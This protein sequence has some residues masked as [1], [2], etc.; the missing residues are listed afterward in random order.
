MALQT[1][2]AHSVTTD[3]GRDIYIYRDPATRQSRQ[4]QIKIDGQELYN[5]PM[6]ILELA[7][8]RDSIEHVL[9]SWSYTDPDLRLRYHGMIA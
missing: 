1:I 5:R 2:L 3:N 6:D 8:L 7:A 9:R 4:Y